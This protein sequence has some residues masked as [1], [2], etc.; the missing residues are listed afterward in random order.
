MGP[1]RVAKGP[2]QCDRC[3]DVRGPKDAML[4]KGSDFRVDDGGNVL[5]VPCSTRGEYHRPVVKV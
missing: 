4:P 2:V 1:V 3:H 5:C